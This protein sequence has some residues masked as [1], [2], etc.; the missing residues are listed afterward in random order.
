MGNEAGVKWLGL[1]PVD[2]RDDSQY[3]SGSSLRANTK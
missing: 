1:R 2:I 3:V